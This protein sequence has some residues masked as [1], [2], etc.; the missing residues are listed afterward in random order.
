MDRGIS[1]IGSYQDVARTKDLLERALF[2]SGLLGVIRSNRTWR[3]DGE[4]RSYKCTVFDYCASRPVD[5]N[6]SSVL[7]MHPA[8][9]DQIAKE[10]DEYSVVYPLHEDDDLVDWEEHAEVS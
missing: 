5:R 8:L 9:G 4:K 2:R 3:S 7:G 10:E 1:G 6:D